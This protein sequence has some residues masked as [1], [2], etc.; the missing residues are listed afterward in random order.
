MD[1]ETA[2]R[3]CH[4]RAAIYRKWQWPRKLYAKNHE[5]SLKDRVPVEDQ[6]EN[7][8]QEWDEDGCDNTSTT[9]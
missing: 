2:C 6:Q 9:A 8:W 3:K 4:V 5:I 7:D 1:F